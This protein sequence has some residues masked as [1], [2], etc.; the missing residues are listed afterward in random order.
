MYSC[1]CRTNLLL[2]I[3]LLHF[4]F[5]P[6]EQ[7]LD[8]GLDVIRNI[9]S[10]EERLGLSNHVHSGSAVVVNAADQLTGQFVCRVRQSLV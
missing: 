8:V 2:F 10:L 4:L 6:S 7:V 9:G 5:E 1:E 3:H